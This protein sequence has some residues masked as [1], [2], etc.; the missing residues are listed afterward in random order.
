MEALNENIGLFEKI[1]EDYV[2]V[3]TFV[4][5]ELASDIVKK[6]SKADSPYKLRML[7][8]ALV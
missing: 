2:S 7:G 6:F 8:E 1:T 4:T 3:D 5:S